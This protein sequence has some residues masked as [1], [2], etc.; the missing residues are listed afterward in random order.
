[1]PN[2]SPKKMPDTSA[3]DT[4]ELVVSVKPLSGRPGTSIDRAIS[5][6]TA[7][8]LGNGLIG[9]PTDGI[10]HLKLLLEALLEGV[11]ATGQVNAQAAGQCVRCL[12]EVT[13]PVEVTFQE[14][15]V[16][17]E[18]ADGT[19]SAGQDF[20]EG[21]PTVVGQT[22]D[23]NPAVRDAVVLAL[24]FGPLCRDD[25]PGLCPQCGVPLAEQPDHAH[26]MVDPRWAVLEDILEDKK[27]EG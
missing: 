15:F 12:G 1:M 18:R 20:D 26:Q 2:R 8:G 22:V 6:K 14:L 24:P 5:F 17:P 25:C 13:M 21:Q 19:A 10:V 16:Y 4:P 3:V 27:E 23:L 7:Q 11:L 9:V